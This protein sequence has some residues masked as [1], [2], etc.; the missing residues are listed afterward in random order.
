MDI[1]TFLKGKKTYILVAC[2][3][4]VAAA[5]HLG[6]LDEDTANSA[7]TLLGIGTVATLRAGISSLLGNKDA[8]DSPAPHAP[9][10]DGQDH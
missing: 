1:L 3:L 8:A 7:L 4:A 5:H 6:V 10:G 9:V 2:G